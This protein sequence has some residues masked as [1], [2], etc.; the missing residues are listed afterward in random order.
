M[1]TKKKKEKTNK[2]TN[3]NNNDKK[4]M[5]R[6]AILKV[7]KGETSLRSKRFRAVSDFGIAVRSPTQIAPQIAAEIAPCERTLRLVR[8]IV[9]S[10]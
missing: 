8:L 1:T 9:A 3:K 7:I 4:K 6:E 2:Q 5:A 10:P